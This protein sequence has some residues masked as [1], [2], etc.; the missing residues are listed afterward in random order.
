MG[1]NHWDEWRRAVKRTGYCPALAR[2][3][4]FLRSVD[5]MT[6]EQAEKLFRNN[7]ELQPM[8]K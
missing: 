5:R 1:A 2:A 3:A 7:R 4:E 8:G 6:P